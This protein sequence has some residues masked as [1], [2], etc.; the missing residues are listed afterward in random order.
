MIY[1][2]AEEVQRIA[3]RTL[4]NKQAIAQ[5]NKQRR[6][7]LVDMFG[8]SQT[9]FGDADYPATVYLSVSPDLIHYMRF[10][11]KIGIEPFR[12]T[13]KSQTGSAVV[14]VEPTELEVSGT[15]TGSL[16]SSTDH[17]GLVEIEYD[18]ESIAGGVSPNPHDHDTEAH[19]HEILSGVSVTHTTASDFRISIDGVD[20][21]PYL[22]AQHDGAWISGEGI[23]PTN[24]IEGKEDFYDILDVAGLM[25]AAGETAMHDKLLAPG[26]KKVEVSSGSPFQV[27]VYE[28]IKYN[29][30]AR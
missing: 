27:T 18:S 20:V 25:Y 10:Q 19:T 21:T 15:S 4:D 1:S 3:E 17:R 30:T 11:L 28:Y 12:N 2:Y 8:E 16:S 9:A 14:D 24:K 7:G 13:V 29:Y 6:N 5:M 23:F 26:F 22:M